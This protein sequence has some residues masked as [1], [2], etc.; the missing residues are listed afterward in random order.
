MKNDIGE[1]ITKRDL[2]RRLDKKNSLLSVQNIP[3]LIDKYG[4]N[5]FQ[6]YNLYNL[7]KSFEK[8]SLLRNIKKPEMEGV[9]EKGIDRETF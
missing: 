2:M 4:L 1:T 7:Y 5:R 6:I 8:V 9:I 3:Y